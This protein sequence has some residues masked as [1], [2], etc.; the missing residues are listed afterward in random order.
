MITAVVSGSFKF[1]PEI[2]KTIETLEE[3]GI[4]VIEPVKG[5]LILPTSEISERLRFGQIR[6]LPTEESLSTKQI[7]DR[8]LK[9]LGRAN[10]MY[11]MNHEGYVG[12]SVS[13]EIGYALGRQKPIYALEAL[14]YEAM[15]INDLSLIKTLDQSVIVLRPEEVAAHYAETFSA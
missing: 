6:P 4:K 1:K 11:L 14:D 13:L 10:L 12:S 2:D 8:F 9:A 7:E 3:T 15:E 5:W